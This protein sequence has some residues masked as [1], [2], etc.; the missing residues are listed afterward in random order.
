MYNFYYSNTIK[1][2]WFILFGFILHIIAAYLSMGYYSADEH[3]Q[4][5]APLEK[6]L[7]IETK[8]TWEFEYKIRPW[9]Q[10]YFYFFIIKLIGFFN[11][12]NP[13]ILAFI[14]RLIS[15]IIGFIS[16]IYLFNYLKL[17]FNLDNNISK[18]LIF[19][20]SFYAF[21]HARTSSENLSISML[22]FGLIFFDKLILSNLKN[23]K[24]PLSII[25]GIFL[26]LSMVF[27][28][29]IFIS[30]FFIYLWFLI[31]KFNFLNLRYVFY[32]GLVI[33]FIL[34]LCLI[35]D[36]FGYGHFNNTYFKYYHANFVD[37]WF[38]SFGK[39]PWWYYIQ[40]LIL[41]FFP[42]ISLIISISLVY[43]WVKNLKSLFTYITL[44]V[45]ITLSILSHK[46]LRFL[47]PILVFSPFF[48]SYF[49]CNTNI[50]FAKTSL[51]TCIV[52]L[53]I[54]F[55]ILLFI[56]A[57]EQIKIYK[58]LYE[59]KNSYDELFYYDE[60]PYLIDDLEPK[61]YTN[62]L[63][64][65]TEYEKYEKNK[66]FFIVIRDYNF[67][68]EIVQINNCN[69]IFSVY[70]DFI[71]LNKNWRERKFNWYIVHCK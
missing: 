49:L 69:Y 23:I 17:K 11:I 9:L 18:F 16:I 47:F 48:I 21:L 5:I 19:G 14:L 3:F 6:L 52:I 13:F 56:P 4:I 50:F 62:V 38:E 41:N 27:K 58:F 31:N 8:L 42:P 61:F 32:S 7:E 28:F 53:N 64:N 68:K 26:G 40:L 57:T 10:P 33:I 63:P 34:L 25:S 20:F 71:N 65:I 66:N 39:D 44:P 15:S 36:Y 12:S 46:E 54:I 67:Y 35:F 55:M 43:F 29:Q 2:N 1:T 45:F 24:L 60:N 70:P 51:T 22:I 30:V 59:N 37:K